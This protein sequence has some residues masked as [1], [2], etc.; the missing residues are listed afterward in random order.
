[1]RL[2]IASVNKLV[3]SVAEGNQVI[4]R[5][6][7]RATAEPLVVGP[8]GFAGSTGLTSPT[9]PLKNLSARC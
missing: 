1:L 2:R 5:V 6:V 9:I 8:E 4:F 7:A 3:T